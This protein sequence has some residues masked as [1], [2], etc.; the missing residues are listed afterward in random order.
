MSSLPQLVSATAN[1]HKLAEIAGILDGLVELLPRP[2]HVAEVV[3]DAGTL[4]GNAR[5]KAAAICAATGLPAVSDDTGL[6]VDALGGEPGVDTAYY[7]GPHA[8]YAENRAKLLAVL[9]GVADRRA[10]FRTIVMVV[11]PDGRELCVEGMCSGTIAPEERGE[12]GFGFDPLFVP[13]DGDGR[14]FSLMTDSEK[15]EISHRGRA[16]VALVDALREQAA[17]TPPA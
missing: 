14:T 16:F 1:P 11:W 10:S 12:R 2:A 17:F 3:E 5:L 7:A 15:N 13:D 9:S 6:F 4:E 8:T